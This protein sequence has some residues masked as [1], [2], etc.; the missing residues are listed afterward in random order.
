M[1]KLIFFLMALFITTSALAQVIEVSNV[2]AGSLKEAILAM[3]IMP[4]QVTE[5]TITSGDLNGTDI[6][7]LRYMAGSDENAAPSEGYNL[8]VLDL[9]GARIV[10]GGDY[11]V[12]HN[13]TDTEEVYT[14]TDT[15][16][17][18]MFVMCENLK[19]IIL[20][21]SIVGI[22]GQQQFYWCHD[23][24][25]IV[26]S[27]LIETIEESMFHTCGSLNKI[28]FP[29]ALKTIGKSAFA[30]CS[31]LTE[32]TIPTT[33]TSIEVGAFEMCAALKRV[34]WNPNVKT[35][36]QGTFF[37]CTSLETFENF[38]RQV[39]FVGDAAFG[40]CQALTIDTV[41]LASNGTLGK[42]PFWIV[43]VKA[44]EVPANNAEY[45][46]LDG[47]LFNKDQTELLRYNSGNDLMANYTV[48][49]SV[50]RIADFAF[51][52]SPLTGVNLPT[53]LTNL[54]YGA[55]YMNHDLTS[56]DIPDGVEVLAER[57]FR[58][59]LALKEV[60]LPA[61]LKEIEDECFSLCI[62]LTEL[63]LPNQLEFLG[64]NIF[65][66]TAITKL[67]LPAS[68]N[69]IA[70][71]AFAFMTLDQLTI[72]KASTS[73][74]DEGEGA[75][76]YSKDKKN[77]VKVTRKFNDPE[78]IV[79]AQT[80]TIMQNALQYTFTPKVSFLNPNCYLSKGCFTGNQIIEVILPAK[81][82]TIQDRVFSSCTDLKRCVF[83][84]G[85][86]HISRGAFEAA[87][88]EQIIFPSTLSSIEID[89]FDS[90]V[91][92]DTVHCLAVEPPAA[93]E[94]EST[95]SF[96][97]NRALLNKVLVVP[98]GSKKAY[99]TRDCWRLFGKIIESETPS[100]V[101]NPLSSSVKVISSTGGITIQ[102]G[103]NNPYWVYN[104]QG[105]I[106]SSGIASSSHTSI[107][108]RSGLYI[109]QTSGQRVKVS[110][111]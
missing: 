6:R 33:V 39:E 49:N 20:P 104:I 25:S 57:T 21:R 93:Y 102:G 100:S 48:P 23:L 79:P 51:V 43:K 42:D 85:L 63:T 97:E 50:T 56:I 90:R 44:F 5:L 40:D 3:S 15:L 9:A 36:Y 98:I 2:Q 58:S 83:P 47:V 61:H 59:C 65:Y 38:P 95:C 22:D 13:N 62:S 18:G 91:M 24:E 89:G 84:E 12:K 80:D 78:L 96:G 26:L 75:V 64:N 111:K 68:V 76:V 10:S 109:V 7:L 8:S 87:P 1:K 77:L 108:L 69:T 72:D 55:F 71:D 19:S 70:P 92:C 94:D 17:A 86:R 34:V 30:F 35:I 107:A 81:I 53:G 54:G 110:V 52:R 67:H 74:M 60:K 29:T 99:E 82:D 32:V 28:V 66:S 37:K 88:L 101:Q 73:Y 14:Q 103:E 11:Y 45:S 31:S 27:P 16:T 105:A 41:S 4:E 106:A 46:S